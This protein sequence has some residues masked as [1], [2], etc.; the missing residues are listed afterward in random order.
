MPVSIA[1][2][3]AAAVT[4]C[5]EV[6]AAVHSE[7]CAV[8]D[9]RLEV[10]RELL[11][12]LPSLRPE[13]GAASVTRKVDRLSCVRYGSARYSVP[14]RLIGATVNVVI[15]HGALVVVEPGTGAIVAEHELVAPGRHRSS[16]RT[17][18]DLGHC[19]T[20]VHARKPQ[21]NTSSALWVRTRRR[22]WWARPQSATP[23]SVKNSRSC[24]RWVP[25]TASNNWWRRCGGRWRSGGS[26]PPMCA[27]S[28][29]P[30]PRRSPARP[31]MRWYWTCP[32]R[33]P[34][35]WTPTRS[36]ARVTGRLMTTTAGTKPVVPR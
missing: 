35:P 24:S 16:M 17:T 5:A 14:T 3:N 4:W 28:W 29:P 34:A 1:A 2:A 32:P 15:D 18:T 13:I 27:P 20:V 33:P 23:A 7:I 36:P 31:G 9:E 26:A 21:P 10:E 8:P 6:N 19:P 11:A 22:S 12:P 25:L 30:A